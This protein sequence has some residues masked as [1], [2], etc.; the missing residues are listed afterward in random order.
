[1]TYIL[2]TLIIVWPMIWGFGMYTAYY[3]ENWSFLLTWPITEICIVLCLIL[4]GLA[5][6][7]GFWICY[8]IFYLLPIKYLLG[9]AIGIFQN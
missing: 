7:I 3:S 8:F 9:P 4:G 2:A 6:F 1:M 5:L